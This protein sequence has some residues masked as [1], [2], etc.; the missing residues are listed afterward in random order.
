MPVEGNVENH[1]VSVLAW[2]DEGNSRYVSYAISHRANDEGTVIGSVTVE[3]DA[4]T[5]GLG[6][7][8]ET[9]IV[10]ASGDTAAVAVIKMLEECGYTYT[11]SGALK[12]D[13]YL[14]SISRTDAFRGAAIEP[15]L[16]RLIERDGITFLPDSGRDK[17]GEFDYTRGSGW[18][19]FLNGEYCP[20]KSMSSY[21]LNGGERISLRFTLA[22]GKDVGSSISD[23]NTTLQSYCGKWVNDTIIEYE[24]QYE[25]IERV[26]PTAEREGYIFYRCHLCKEEKQQALIYEGSEEELP[27]EGEESENGQ[28]PPSEGGEPESGQQ[29]P[30]EGEEPESGQNP[31]TEG[32]ESENGQNP[33]S[34]GG[35][36]ESEQQ[37]PS[38]GEESEEGQEQPSEG[39]NLKTDSN[40][41]QRRKG[42]KV[43][44]RHR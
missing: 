42:R 20:G 12:N 23:T 21:T 10:I 37:L 9:E 3:I 1:T 2:D 18:M 25:Q 31:P 14:S 8:E 28:E 7:I 15:R 36:P 13:F 44:K 19:Y 4:T 33:P 35:E 39:E 6:I 17:L 41:P 22:F 40:H 32:E 5:L 43:S 11:N 29:P 24:H 26:E 34:E 16:R 38:E 30:S 27:T